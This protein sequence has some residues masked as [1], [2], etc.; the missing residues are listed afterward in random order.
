VSRVASQSVA[1]FG[2]GLTSMANPDSIT[3]LFAILG[4]GFFLGMRHASDPDHVIAVSTI[5]TRERRLGQ[6]HLIGLVIPPWLG[7]GMEFSVG[8]MLVLLGALNIAAL[9]RAGTDQKA[10]DR[11]TIHTH[12]HA[13]GDYIHTHAHGHH[14]ESHP[15]R[16]DTTPVAW[17]DRHF[18]GLSSYRLL[19]PV[20]IG[21]IHGMAGSA[22]I[23]LLILATIQ[24]SRWALGYLVVFGIGTIAGMMLITTIMGST[25]SYAQNRFARFGT[26]LQ[27]AAGILSLCF[28][29][30]LAYQIGIVHG[31]FTGNPQ[32]IP[33]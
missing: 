7:L 32:W 29:L 25:V 4:I 27:A 28:G 19:R 10:G 1:L 13:H 9:L 31:L 33:R 12:T 2:G 3:Q 11:G 17:I 26:G 18:G 22:A 21:L 16:S 6:A 14:P 5:V 8:V 30:F 20:V 24:D 23:A 15:H